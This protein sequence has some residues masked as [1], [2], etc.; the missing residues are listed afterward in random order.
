MIFAIREVIVLGSIDSIL[1]LGNVLFVANW[2]SERGVVDW[3]RYTRPECLTGTAVAC[4][5]LHVNVDG[6][7]RYDFA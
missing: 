1:L 6:V 7:E 5:D 3:A 4:R 2:L